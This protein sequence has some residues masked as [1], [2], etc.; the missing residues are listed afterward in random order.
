MYDLG[1]ESKE[2]GVNV[3]FLGKL[4][5]VSQSYPTHRKDCPAKAIHEYL[6]GFIMAVPNA[7]GFRTESS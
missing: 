5:I 4:N 2:S 3:I 7:T 6:F 1:V